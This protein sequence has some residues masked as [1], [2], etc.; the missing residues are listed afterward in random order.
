MCARESQTALVHTI[1]AP[2]CELASVLGL[3]VAEI[4]EAL[5]YRFA[6]GALNRLSREHNRRVT[7]SDISVVTGL[8]R[9]QVAH[10]LA[11]REPQQRRNPSAAHRA[12]R[13]LSAWHEDVDYLRPDGKPRDLKMDGLFSFPA[14]VNR[15]AGDVPPRSV[16]DELLLREAVRVTPANEVRALKKTLASSRQ[17]AE[18]LERAARQVAE[19]LRALVHNYSA[20]EGADQMFIRDIEVADLE[21]ED[22]AIARRDA[23]SFLEPAL[24]TVL[25]AKRRRRKRSRARDVKTGT[26]RAIVCITTAEETEP[27]PA[28]RPQQHRRRR[29]TS[30]SRGSRT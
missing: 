8:D 29:S 16:L 24:D 3:S 9:K 15:Y 20:P 11:Q 21:A 7:F 25:H 18:S 28:K 27:D 23:R 14:L 10:L 22:L 12:A 30:K 1:L 17:S 5:R 13:V 2:L 4:E 26:L 19:L 6:R